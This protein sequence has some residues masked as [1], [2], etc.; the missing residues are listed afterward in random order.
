MKTNF[1]SELTYMLVSYLQCG[2]STYSI[3]VRLKLQACV[4]YVEMAAHFAVA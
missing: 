3:I 1:R 4:G 2:Q